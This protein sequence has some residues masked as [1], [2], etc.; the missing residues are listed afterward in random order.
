MEVVVEIAV[1][2]VEG[3]EASHQEVVVEVSFQSTRRLGQWF[4]A[5]LPSRCSFAPLTI[6]LL[7]NRLLRRSRF[8]W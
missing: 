2:E 7:T 5:K 3:E 6:A 8:W 4:L 1:V